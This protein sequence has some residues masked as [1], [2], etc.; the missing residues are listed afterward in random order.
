MPTTDARISSRPTRSG[1]DGGD[2][3][4]A[5]Q[6]T[7]ASSGVSSSGPA[8][9]L[10]AEAGRRAASWLVQAASSPNRMS[11]TRGIRPV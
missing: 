9:S 6:R 4:V 3:I 2:D 7:A 5:G 1:D 10:A 8:G 11:K